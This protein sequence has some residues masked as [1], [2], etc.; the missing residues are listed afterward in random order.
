MSKTPLIVKHKDLIS[1][2]TNLSPKLRSAVI[3]SLKRHEIN[4]ISEIFANFLRKRLTDNP[5]V[6]GKLKK[7]KS[8]IRTVAL[9]KTPL[10][11]KRA[12]LLSKRGGGILAA[13]LPLAASV[14]TSLIKKKKNE[15]LLPSP[16]FRC[17]EIHVQLIFPSG[18]Q[19]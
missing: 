11:K 5:K 9:K 15:N 13:L 3:A 6:I 19:I 16:D 18:R 14:V 8:D 4:C 12:I 17:R 10:Y 1:L 2:L 7:F